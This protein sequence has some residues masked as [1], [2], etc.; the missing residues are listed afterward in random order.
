MAAPSQEEHEAIDF[1]QPAADWACLPNLLKRLWNQYSGVLSVEVA[2]EF[3]LDFLLWVGL[4][5]PNTFASQEADAEH[6]AIGMLALEGA[7]TSL[8][9]ANWDGLL[10]AAMTELGYPEGKYQITVTGED[11]RGPPAAAKLYKFHGCALRAIANQEEYRRLLVA[12]SA[13]ITGWKTNDTFKIVRDQLGAVIQV[14]RTLMIGMSAQDENIKHLFAQVNAHKGWKWNDEPPPI[15]F[16]G[17]E[18]GDDQKNLLIL[19]Y[20]EEDYQDNQAAICNAALIQAYAK[21]LLIALLLDVLTTKLKIL[22][23]D[24]H[25]PQLDAAA[26]VAIAMGLTHLRDRVANMDNGDRLALAR[27]IACG[28]ARARHQLQNG[29][30]PAGVPQYFPLD[31]GPAHLM[32]GKLSLQSS[33]QRQAAAALGLIG[34]DEQAAAWTTSADDPKDATAGALRLTSQNGT[35]RVFLAANDDTIAHLVGCGAF[36]EDDED[37]VLICSGAVSGRQQRSP[38]RDRR[39]GSLGPR[40][41]GFGPM[42]AEAGGLDDLRERFRDEVAL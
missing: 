7:V 14:N 6:L 40:Y 39:D 9:T 19:S 21:P 24:V 22:A 13:Q 41:I 10:E 32:K 30:S 23:S 3:D 4:D 42:L 35:A 2:P 25:A 31:D 36:D 29:S 26:H 15:V 8:A 11:L 34:L 1:A 38:S 18:L 20:G 12:R 27:G 33:G 28:L 17:Q 16:S 5:F 37:V